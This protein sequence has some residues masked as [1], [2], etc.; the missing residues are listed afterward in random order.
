MIYD[1]SPAKHLPGLASLIAGKLK[2]NNRCLYLNT[3]P[4]VA[5]IR[6]YL[7]AAG[8]D[9]IG[10]MRKGSLVLSSEQDHLVDGHFDIGRMLALLVESLDRALDDGYS[11]LFAMGDMT[12][13]FG[14]ERDFEKLQEY[15]RG[16]EEI[17]LSRPEL[18]GICQYHTQTL[19]VHAAE[20]ALG[21]HRA[22]FINQTLCLMNPYYEGSGYKNGD[23]HSL[24][25]MM[26]KPS[27]HPA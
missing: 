18:Q 11:G 20:E 22:C 5:G 16:L 13:E 27:E 6:S 26:A 12:W 3:R 23:S 19:P 4:M 14:P 17:F 9:V 2:S 24:R 15:E 1:G 25:E 21:L 10:E 7:A 8:V